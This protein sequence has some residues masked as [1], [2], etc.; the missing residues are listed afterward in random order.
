M[1]KYILFRSQ[2]YAKALAEKIGAIV[3]LCE[4]G[5]RGITPHDGDIIIVDAHYEGNMS[6]M[7][8]FEIVKNLQK[9]E[10]RDK[11]VKYKILSWFPTEW[12]NEKPELKSHK[13]QLYSQR[14][15]VFFQLPVSDP[16]KI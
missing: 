13:E 2:E 11:D 14:N 10:F 3:H 16:N 15:V 1:S 5:L 12:L 8:G 6:D 9:F 4:D 7:S